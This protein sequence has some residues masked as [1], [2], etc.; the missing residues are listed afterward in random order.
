MFCLLW[1]FFSAE[2]EEQCE[3]ITQLKLR[4]DA[5]EASKQSDISVAGTL[6]ETFRAHIC[7]FIN[8]YL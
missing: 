2:K 8:H 5:Y 1:F 6:K 4:L 3:F 7:F